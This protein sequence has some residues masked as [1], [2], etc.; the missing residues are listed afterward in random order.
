MSVS[1]IVADI[2]KEREDMK[3][4]PILD[5]ANV[6]TWSKK[7]K[8]WLMQKKRN[9]LCLE[10]RPA[11]PPNNASA[12]AK[13]EYRTAQDTWL[14]RKDTCV[15]A[16]YEAVEGIPDALEIPDQCILVKRTSYLKMTQ[17]RKS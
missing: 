4:L 3:G 10:D 15:S 2:N 11:R 17:T 16:I 8:M 14:E 7:L 1:N 5:L 9:H 13:T 12:V 6:V